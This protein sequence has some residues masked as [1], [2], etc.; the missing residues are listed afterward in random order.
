M[1]AIFALVG[2]LVVQSPERAKPFV[3]NVPDLTITIHATTEA[4]GT[5]QSDVTTTLYCK[6]A[7]QREDHVVERGVFAGGRPMRGRFI[8]QC[9]ERRMV[10]LNDE[11]KTYAFQPLYDPSDSFRRARRSLPAAPIESTS[12]TDSVDTGERRPIGPFVARHVLTSKRTEFRSSS[13]IRLEE[14]D[15]W[16]VDLPVGCVDW[17]VR[18]ELYDTTPGTP[19]GRMI[20][21]G[22]GR[23]G[24]P[25][26]ETTRM[27]AGSYVRNAEPTTAVTVISRRE[28][29]DVSEYV[30]DATIDRHFSGFAVDPT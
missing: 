25:V 15:G 16:Y 22:N 11:A 29:I 23:R 10:L 26:I 24:Y 21:R 30:L 12:T 13:T 18:T 14:R 6:G 7:L 17:A 20:R 5:K 27:P 1:K 28:L 9:D 3:P 8:T 4:G 2:L 19:R